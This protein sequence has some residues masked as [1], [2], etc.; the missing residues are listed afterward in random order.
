MLQVAQVVSSHGH[1]AKAASAPRLL[2]RRVPSH[3]GDLYFFQV[4]SPSLAP[5]TLKLSFFF[6]APTTLKLSQPHDCCVAALI[7]R[8]HLYQAKAVKEIVLI[9]G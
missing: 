9:F 6:L 7:S 1:Q 5:A 4:S 2:S 3:L 8:Q